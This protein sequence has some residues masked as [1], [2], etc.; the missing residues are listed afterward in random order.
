MFYLYDWFV[1]VLISL[2]SGKIFPLLMCHGLFSRIFTILMMHE[3]IVHLLIDDISPPH[4]NALCLRITRTFPQLQ[5]FI[6]L[7]L[8]F[9]LLPVMCF[10]PISFM[11]FKSLFMNFA[12]LYTSNSNY[13]KIMN[14]CVSTTL[15]QQVY[16][17]P[18]H[19]ILM[20]IP[21]ILF[22]SH[23][24]LCILVYIYKRILLKKNSDHK[25]IIVHAAK[26]V[27][28]IHC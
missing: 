6:G 2:K 9:C 10:L 13:V 26:S 20:Q 18:S 1:C 14:P 5:N 4:Q 3:I 28:S 11:F 17:S 21:N 19:I 8:S 23:I 25:T 12:K 15:L 27:S 16:F 7:I 24:F 22:H